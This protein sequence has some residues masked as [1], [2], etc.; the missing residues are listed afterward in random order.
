VPRD[1]LD[2]MLAAD[3]V[4]LYPSLHSVAPARIEELANQNALTVVQQFAIPDFWRFPEQH[5]LTGEFALWNIINVVRVPDVATRQLPFRL[6]YPGIYRHT[7]AVEF[8][9]VMFPALKPGHTSAHDAHFDYQ[10]TYEVAPR[11]AKVS[12][13]L[14]ILNDEVAPSEWRGFNEALAKLRP[15]LFRSV[16]TNAMSLADNK[17]L[18]AQLKTLVGRFRQGARSEPKSRAAPIL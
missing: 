12:G 6:Q 16:T 4:R 14:T 11:S 7:I 9:D 1:K 10:M 2:S 13:T 8:P 5:A 18:N 15:K 3:Y 17:K